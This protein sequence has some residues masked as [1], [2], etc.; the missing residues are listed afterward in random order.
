M[1]S[2]SPGR[3]GLCWR[4][5]RFVVRIGGVG[6]DRHDGA[7]RRRDALLGEPVAN[8]LGHVELG[9]PLPHAFPGMGEGFVDDAAQLEGCIVV[10]GVLLRRPA[11]GGGLHQVGG[12]HHLHAHA[13]HQL[14]GTGV[15]AGDARQLVHRRVFH[16]QPPGAGNQRA[17]SRHQG[18]AVAVH[19]AVHA[20]AG[21]LAGVHVVRQ[22]GGRSPRGEVEVAGPGDVPRWPYHLP[23]DGVGLAVVVYQPAR[24]FVLRHEFLRGDVDALK[25]RCLPVHIHPE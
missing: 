6:V 22:Q 9:H 4:A 2:Q 7:V 14:H 17:Q 20:G 18:L 13:A 5:G 11:V 16:R 10:V 15:H 12:G 19:D 1:S 25:F 3:M 21:E 8:E 23:E 24:Y